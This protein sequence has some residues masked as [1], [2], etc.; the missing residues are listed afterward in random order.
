[1]TDFRDERED[2][3]LVLARPLPFEEEEIFFEVFFL[4]GCSSSSVSLSS[5]SSAELSWY[6]CS[7]STNAERVSMTHRHPHDR[8]RREKGQTWPVLRLRSRS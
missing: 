1:M 3:P 6:A 5:V 8:E 4:R 2:P 7:T